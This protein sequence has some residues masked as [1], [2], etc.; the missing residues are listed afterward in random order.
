MEN[1][2]NPLL[3]LVKQEDFKRFCFN[4]LE[5]LENTNAA[6]IRVESNQ[7][8]SLNDAIESNANAINEIECMLGDIKNG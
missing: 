6:L 1:I 4:V 3:E 7:M 8:N 2:T 5:Y